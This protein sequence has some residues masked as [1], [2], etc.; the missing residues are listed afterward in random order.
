MDVRGRALMVETAVSEKVWH[1]E[2]RARRPVW[3]QHRG[4][5]RRLGEQVREVA[6]N[7]SRSNG[8]LQTIVKDHVQCG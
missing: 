4:L 3:L 1:G 5:G 7:M 2:G 8:T 6:E